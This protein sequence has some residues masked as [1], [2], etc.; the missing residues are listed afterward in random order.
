[1]VDRSSARAEHPSDIELGIS[2]QE[3]DFTK[4]AATCPTKSITASEI[5]D[6]FIIMDH[7][8]DGKVSNV[9]FDEAL[10]SDSQ[11]A[12]KFGLHWTPDES[13]ILTLQKNDLLFGQ[14]D[15]DRS[16]SIDVGSIL[17]FMTGFG[18]LICLQPA[19]QIWELLNFYGHEDIDM[20]ELASLL[21]ERGYTGK[22]LKEILDKA[23]VHES[24]NS[25]YQS[26]TPNPLKPELYQGNHV[27]K[28]ADNAPRLESG[29]SF[30]HR[31][32]V[33]RQ[34]V[35]ETDSGCILAACSCIISVLGPI[36]CLGKTSVSAGSSDRQLKRTDAVVDRDRVTR[37]V[38]RAAQVA[39][40]QPPQSLVP[41]THLPTSHLP[42][43]FLHPYP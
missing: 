22:Y 17:R 34:F 23:S 28:F 35:P 25:M 30:M 19:L 1:M 36:V 20:A 21:S 11:L 32:N 33:L 9:E 31:S 41:P 2:A 10:K 15:Y 5:I 12:Q 39:R 24:K 14:I 37:V 16:K 8:R 29:T 4:V 27:K 3:H 6:C 40:S 18:R 13:P 38:F 42:P 26:T 43:S 7:N